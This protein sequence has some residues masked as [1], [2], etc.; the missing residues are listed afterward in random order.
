MKKNNIHN[1]KSTGFKVP[2]D[3]FASLEA[4]ILSEVKLKELASDPGYKVPE[5]YFDSLED[6]IINTVKPQKETKVVKLVTW[7]KAAYAVAV[8]ASLILTINLFFTNT[9]PVAIEN[10][11]TA[12]IENY[13][14]NEDLELNEFA[15]LFTSEDLL[16]VRLIQDGYSSKNLEDYVF[17]HIEIEDIITN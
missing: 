16:D 5:N 6:K 1:I 3:Y 8:A 4:G 7:R 13:I 10:I 12:S 17:D 11:E 9:T 14:L 15:S 2:K